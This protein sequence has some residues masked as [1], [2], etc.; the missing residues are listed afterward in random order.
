MRALPA[1]DRRRGRRRLRRRRRDPRD[2]LR[3]APRHAAARRS[4]SCS[5]ASASPAA[6]WAPARS[7]RASSARAAPPSCCT[8]AARWAPTRR[9]R[10]G[11]FNRLVAPERC[12]AE[13]H[14]ARRVARARPDVRARDDEDDAAPGVGDGRR[15]GDRGRGAGAGDLHADAATSSA[16]T[17]PSRQARSRCSRATDA[18][19]RSF[20]SWPFFDDAHRALTAELDAF[21]ADLGELA[22]R[23]RRRRRDLPRARRARSA[24]RLAALACRLRAASA[25]RAHAVPGARDARATT[26]ALRRL[27][28]RDAGPRQRRR[29]RCSARTPQR[30]ALP[31]ARSRPARRSPRSRCRA[32]GRLRRR[33]AARR[34]ATRDGDAYVLDG[35]K[36]W[37]SNGGIADFYVVFA[38]T[39][40]APGARGL[41]A[42]RRRRRHARASRSRERID[43][44]A[45]HPLATLRFDGCRVPADRLIGEAGDGFKVAMATLDVFR[46]TVGAAALGFARRALDEALA[47]VA[48]ARAVRRA[49]RRLPARRRPR[50]PR[51]RSTIDAAALLV[52][53]A[54]WTKD[55]GAERDHARGGDGEAVRDRGGAARDRRAPC[56]CT[57]GSA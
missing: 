46:S 29:S 9:E 8:P 47:H 5:R 41:S 43:V 7:C 12:C 42:L 34:R 25:R 54:A 14:G 24:R 22:A 11:F 31:A 44:I 38:R 39:G 19:T 51:W 21:G 17:K 45:P 4:R 20:L 32:G 27:R 28:V 2:G 3:H 16:P 35:E 37:I 6:T 48:R 26:T 53:R 55:A 50:S 49:A 10:W 1:A 13:A 30:A 52:Y 33:R 40:E 23:R 18:P 36:T 15:R 56:S 57:A